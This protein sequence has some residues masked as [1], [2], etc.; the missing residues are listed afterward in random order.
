MI[1]A[2]LAIGSAGLYVLL[3]V[4][5]LAA[6]P[7]ER[8]NRSLGLLLLFLAGSVIAFYRYRTASVSNE[9]LLFAHA[10]SWYELPLILLVG[11]LADEMFLDR[12]RPRWRRGLLGLI[13][14][15]TVLAALVHLVEPSTFH[16]LATDTDPGRTIGRAG[17]HVGILAALQ[18]AT[19]DLAW[20]V[21]VGLAAWAAGDNDRSTLE[22]RHAALVGLAFSMQVV[23]GGVTAGLLSSVKD[24]SILATF[25]P[26]M[27]T[28]V[29]LAGLATVLASWRRLAA[30]FQGASR[31]VL[32]ALPAVPLM[33]GLYE[34]GAEP[35]LG[36]P[37]L[38]LGLANTRPLWIAAFAVMVTVAVVRYG[39]AGLATVS[40]RRLV[41]ITG[42]LLLVAAL[43][44]ALGVS[45]LALGVTPIA[46]VTTFVAA[47]GVLVLPFTRVRQLPRRLMDAI[48]L[49]PHAPMVARE[50][51]RAY[52]RALE[53]AAT[54]DG[55]IDPSKA[56]WLEG[57]RRDLGLTRRDHD[58]LLATV[59]RAETEAP[60][61][62]AGRYDVLEPIGA[63]GSGQA[64]LAR[65]SHLGRRVVLKSAAR[66]R[67]TG[68]A[69]A[70]ALASLDHPHVV[71]IHDIVDGS[72]G[73]ILVLEHVGGG[74]L[75]DRLEE[76]GPWPPDEAAELVDAVLDALDTVHAQGIIH[77]DVTPSNVLLTEDGRPK[78]A[79]FGTA[80]WTDVQED[81]TVALAPAEA[82][83]SAMAPEQARGDPITPAT[84]VYAAGVLLH[85][86]ITGR[87]PL[88]VAGSSVDEARHA[89]QH[90]EP[91]LDTDRLPDGVASVIEA[92]LAKDA[93]Q[94]PSLRELRHALA[95]G[96][97]PG[98][99]RPA[100][101]P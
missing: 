68:T 28:W 56:G 19:L 18:G 73:P 43:G 49:D 90:R 39:L 10:L 86:L 94:R 60:D 89:V 52:R 21:M 31:R 61:L 24:P 41:R 57:L 26:G 51:A 27:H 101:P 72:E 55:T 100:T 76:H 50:R 44:A 22:R 98:G 95:P 81:R 64:L 93:D 30:P 37:P 36:L 91:Q 65:D 87:A 14:G 47:G 38:P 33:A 62:V 83:L 46:L 85:R 35:L 80:R 54:A 63:G 53:E 29:N 7:R 3:G 23:H 20:L 13:G 34:G 58:L 9:G 6:R 12:V 11:L 1:E 66:D 70:E 5:V 16:R 48:L 59:T 17:V 42:A 15:V 78:L 88:D 45:V 75:A 96:I 92:A 77:G 74:S 32:A 69:E 84:D 79:D 40:G 82:T 2:A 71:T 4:W 67:A 8:V 97:D 99:T 25:Q